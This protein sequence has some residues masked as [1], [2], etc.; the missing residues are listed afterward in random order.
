VT[1]SDPIPCPACDGLHN[2]PPLNAEMGDMR[3][4]VCAEND[5][6]ADATPTIG[7]IISALYGACGDACYGSTYSPGTYPGR[8]LD[9]AVAYVAGT[10][11]HGL[12]RALWTP[13]VRALCKTGGFYVESI[14]AEV[15]AIF[16]DE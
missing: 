16:A 15:S 10:E 5:M 8:H 13:E 12:L 1:I 6:L 11:R 7:T 2:V 4:D 3:C 14:N 9:G